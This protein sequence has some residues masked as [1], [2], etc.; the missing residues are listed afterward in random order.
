[1]VLAFELWFEAREMC[2]GLLTTVD[3]QHKIEK[4]F[5]EN[6]TLWLAPGR[7][8]WTTQGDSLL[9]PYSSS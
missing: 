9:D 8:S 2:A 4:V 6:E 5:L 1:M 7:A 3:N